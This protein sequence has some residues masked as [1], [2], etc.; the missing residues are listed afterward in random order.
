MGV[1]RF[2]KPSAWRRSRDPEA[3]LGSLNRRFQTVSRR[4]ER[5][6]R[7]RRFL[8]RTL[9]LMGIVAVLTLF[10]GAG[11]MFSPW[12]PLLT[13]Q[14]IAAAPNCSAARLVGLA[15][16]YR[17]EPGYYNSHDRDKDGWACEPMPGSRSQHK[18]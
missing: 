5:R 17:G 16:A 3:A 2:P 10:A 4:W 6:S 7:V 13:L 14:H 15:P 12:P 11:L 8:R 1:L 18:H 9:P